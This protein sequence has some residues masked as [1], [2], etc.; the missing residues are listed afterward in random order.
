MLLENNLHVTIAI[1]YFVE[2]FN[3]NESNKIL[4]NNIKLVKSNTDIDYEINLIKIDIP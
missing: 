3:N 1:E 2:G 4:F